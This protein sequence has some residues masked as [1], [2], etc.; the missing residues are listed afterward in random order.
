MGLLLEGL[1]MRTGQLVVLWA[2]WQ[3]LWLSGGGCW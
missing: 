1:L 2:G 3:G